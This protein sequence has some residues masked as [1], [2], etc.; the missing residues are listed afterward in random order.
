MEIPANISRASSCQST[1]STTNIIPSSFA[2]STSNVEIS[3]LEYAE[4]LYHRTVVHG[5]DTPTAA[6]TT[7]ASTKFAAAAAASPPSSD[8]SSSSSHS[9]PGP[10]PGR[11]SITPSLG[12]KVTGT[13]FG[14][15]RGNVSFAVQYDLRSVP[16]FLV[17][18]AISTATLVNEMSAGMLRIALATEI[19]FATVRGAGVEDVLQRE[20]VRAR[21]GARVQ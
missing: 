14:R 21:A 19:G 3:D 12:R 11:L 4:E 2:C 20:A 13:L 9:L 18:F 17:E 5:G 10:P 16:V 15:R 1:Q 8:P 6:A 7:A